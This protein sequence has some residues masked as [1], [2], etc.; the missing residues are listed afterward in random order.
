LHYCCDENKKIKKI[1]EGTFEL[2]SPPHKKILETLGPVFKKIEQRRKWDEACLKIVLL[3]KFISIYCLLEI[4]CS[5]LQN[6]KIF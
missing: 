6:K 3:S 1:K 5:P 2:P 4:S